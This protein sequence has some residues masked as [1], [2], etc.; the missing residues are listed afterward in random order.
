MND[1]LNVILKAQLDVNRTA[2]DINV[3]LEQ[4]EDKLQS[5]GVDINLDDM[6]KKFN[7][8]FTKV[9]DSVDAIQRSYGKIGSNSKFEESF[10]KLNARVKDIRENV[11]ALAKVKI[12]LDAGGNIQNALITYKNE[13]GQV[14]NTTMSWKDELD[15]LG[16]PTGIKVFEKVWENVSDDISKANKETEKQVELQ[17]KAIQAQEELNI[18]TK[19]FE[20]K[21]LSAL[22]DFGDKIDL[23]AVKELQN[24][25]SN[26]KIDADENSIKDAKNEI[27][28]ILK[29][30][31]NITDVSKLQK[32]INDDLVKQEEEKYIEAKKYAEIYDKIKTKLDNLP[33]SAIGDESQGLYKRLDS[34]IDVDQLKTLQIEVDKYYKS[35]IAGEKQLTAEQKLKQ[36]SIKETF[37]NYKKIQDISTKVDKGLADLNSIKTSYSGANVQDF[38]RMENAW[39]NI[40]VQIENGTMDYE[41]AN[42]A[43]KKLTNSNKDF[44]TSAKKASSATNSLGDRLKKAFQYFTFYDA[45]QM[46]KRALE[47]MVEVIFDLDQ[48]LV[49]LR[50]VSDLTGKSLEDFTR[51][52]Y[53][54]GSQISKSGS[55]IIRASTEFARAG[56]GEDELLNL[57][58]S[59]LVL[60]SIGDGITDV[61]ESAN[62]IIAVL[63]GFNKE[64]SE[65]TEILDMIN[66]VSNNASVSFD[67]VAL[68]LTRMSGT[69]NSSNV[70]LEE[71]I[72]MFTAINEILRNAEMSSTALN[73]ISMRMRGLSEEGDAI[74]GLAPKLNQMFKDIAGIDMTDA[75]GQVRSLFEITNDLAKVWSTLTTNEKT[76]IAQQSAG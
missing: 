32:K 35:A 31:N 14:V 65:T 41:E 44:E 22:Y 16:E 27:S 30:F 3:Q 34:S 5:L 33:K 66:H 52:A 25:L 36:Q 1:D 15:D 10:E 70:K 45:L 13:L 51:Q 72:G 46:G 57:A 53:A 54:L 6:F 49:E 55:Q 59:A 67:Q 56:Y 50:K 24:R 74:D 42:N 20:T 58:E 17:K 29:E 64:T 28:L 68:A 23:N 60:T 12:G 69:M 73:S 26:I 8:S 9:K 4:L 63:R 11:D 61:S 39:K 48:A 38:E 21:S 75:N 18:V 76:Y 37:N 71:S 2:K 43:I 40:R 7:D 19:N 62:T 47:N